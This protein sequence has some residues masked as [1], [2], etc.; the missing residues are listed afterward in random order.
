MLTVPLG[1]GYALQLVRTLTEV[2]D[3]LRQIRWILVFVAAGGIGVA[4]VLGAFVARTALRPVRK[5]TREAETVA[6]TQDLAHRIEVEGHDEL[7]RLGTSFNTMLGAL[8]QAQQAQRRLVADASHELRT[9]LTSLRTNIE[10]IART[11]DLV[12]EKREALL[13][14]L[15]GQLEEMSLLVANLVELANVEA[16]EFEP[17]EVQLDELV[18]EAVDRARRLA[19]QLEIRAELEPCVVRA[20]PARL[21]RAIANLLDN[22]VKWSPPGSEIA[23]TVSG[24][25]LTVRDHGPGISDEDLPHVFDRF[26]RAPSARPLPGSGLGL[27]IVRQVVDEH[28]GSVAI[29]RP[30]EGGTLVRL[31]LPATS[32]DG[33]DK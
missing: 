23:V 21:E 10:V 17:T 11:P 3:L 8:E 15:T 31:T 30:A 32:P 24:G 9:P 1:Q 13:R 26:Y 20:V 12:P 25:E 19:P 2:D 4:A 28:G 5:L 6:Q 33:P 22:A 18:E 7:A 27:S 29:E 16:P 14:D